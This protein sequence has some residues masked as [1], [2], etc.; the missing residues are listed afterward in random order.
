V[1]TG[2]VLA[3]GR[4]ARFG[5]QKLA[6]DV[7]GV[8][9]LAATISAFAGLVDGM[10]VAG[11]QLPPDWRRVW[12]DTS[13]IAI[14]PDVDRFGGP[15][16]ALANVLQHVSPDEDGLAIV[17]GGDMPALVPDVLRAMFDRLDADPSLDALVLGPP[18]RGIQSTTPLHVLPLA[19]REGRARTAVLE[20]VGAGRRSLRSLLDQL[21][22]AELPPADWLPLDPGAGTLLDV[23]TRADLER[24][25]AG[26]GR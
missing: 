21:P 13:P 2:I 4:S 14:I 16:A 19:I 20:A 26:K 11:P 5:G 10:I 18:D 7:D 24:I 8:S 1:R 9:I 12:D 22:W 17:V 23:D 6:A 3:G 25:R 15:L